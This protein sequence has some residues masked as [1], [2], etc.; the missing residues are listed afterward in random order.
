MNA[1]TIKE[2]RSLIEASLLAR[3]DA[4]ASI[5]AGCKR[6]IEPL[7]IRECTILKML[8]MG[9]TAEEISAVIGCG[10]NTVRTHLKNVYSKLGV[11]SSIQA[12]VAGTALGLLS[13]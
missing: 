8:A 11:S 4:Y 5:K 12:V 10:V 7:S 3:A 2:H 9:L 1:R 13:H 6:K